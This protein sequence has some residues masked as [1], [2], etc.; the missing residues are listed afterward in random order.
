[1]WRPAQLAGEAYW[2]VVT[3]DSQFCVKFPD[4]ATALIIAGVLNEH[5]AA[6]EAARDLALEEA[7]KVSDEC[8]QAA[9]GQHGCYR[10]ACHWCSLTEAYEIAADKIRALKKGDTK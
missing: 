5:S 6:R 3:D 7:A 1:M 2:S 4:M 8:K 10:G 9:G